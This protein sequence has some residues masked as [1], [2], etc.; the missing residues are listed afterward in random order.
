[1]Q[2]SNIEKTI[3]DISHARISSYKSF[4]GTND[5]HEVYGIYCWNEEIA[6]ELFKLI[7]MIEIVMRN[8]FHSALSQ[9]YFNHS[10]TAPNPNHYSE[11]SNDWYNKAPLEKKS[12]DCIEKETHYF[13]KNKP[14]ALKNPQPS[15]NNVISNMSFGFWK[16]L[17]DLEITW[18]TLIPEIIPGHRHKSPEHWKTLKNQDKFYARIDLLNKTRNRVAHFE[19][20][21]KL[22]ALYEEIRTRPNQTPA[23]ISNKP[24]TPA[25]SVSRLKLIHEQSIE[26]LKWFSPERATDYV[27]SQTNHRFSWLC[28]VETIDLFKNNKKNTIIEKSKFKRDFN[29]ITKENKKITIIEKNINYG[30][31]FASQ[32]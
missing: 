20:I 13:K 22:G 1:M 23:V 11:H 28:S 30:V 21:W 4:F 17:L 18:S 32:K 7:S 15:P 26:L 27:N 24:T 8:K 19:P 9:Y 29:S 10:Y 14:K 2:P 6:S 31:F 3:D 25:E 12:K 16:N 5:L